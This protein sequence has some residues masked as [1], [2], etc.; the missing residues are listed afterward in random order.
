MAREEH[1]IPAWVVCGAGTGGT[2]AT[3]GRYLRYRRVDT[4]LCVADP[5]ASIFHRHY[6]DR[7]ITSLGACKSSI[8]EGIGRPA[9]NPPSSPM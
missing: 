5:E 2:S 1:P 7:S 8:I 4:Q 6:A 3:I 9:T